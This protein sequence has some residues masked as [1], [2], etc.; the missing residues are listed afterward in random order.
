VTPLV[1]LRIL[2]LI[3][4][5]SLWSHKVKNAIVGAIMMFGTFLVV[6]GSA[7]LDS[8][9]DS[10]ARSITSSMSGHLQV[11]SADA[12]D[13]LSLFGSFGFGSTDIGE[14]DDFAKVERSLLQVDNVAAVVPMGISIVTVFG[15]NDIDKAL[16]ELRAAV[17]EGDAEKTKVLTGRVRR[18]A[19]NIQGDLDA[20]ARIARDQEKVAEDKAVLARATSDEFWASFET[21]PLPALDFLDSQVAPQAA[22]GRLLYLRVIGTDLSRFTKTFDRFHVVKG[23][24]VPEGRRGLL[25][26]DRTHEKLLKNLVARELDGIREDLDGGA[27]I[28][29]DPLLQEKVARLAKQ[30]QSILFQLDADESA[31]LEQALRA[32]LPSEGGDLAAQLRAFI[33]GMD[34]TN[35]RQR[36]DFFYRE[37]A[38]RISLYDVNVGD[39]ITLRSFTK[40]GYIKAVNV[41]VYG[42]YE[43]YG[44]EKS[45]LAS[46]SN[47]LDMITW[48]DLYGK[49]SADQVAELDQ[50]KQSVGVKEISRESAEDALFGGGGEVEA[51]VEPPSAAFDEFEDVRLSDRAERQE[52][53]DTKVYSPEE[54]GGGLALNAA[55]VLR[56]AERLRETQKAVEERSAADDL[57]LQVVDWQRAAGLLGQF[58]IVMR[59][60]LYVAI[61]VIFLVALV[62][63]NNSMVMAT[64]ERTPEIGTMRAI[65]AQRSFVMLLFLVETVVLGCIAGGLGMALGSA[66]VGWLG[67]IGIP[68]V[69]DILVVL[70]AGPRLYPSV[71][72]GNLLFGFGTILV[73]SLLSTMYPAIL[74]ARVAPIVAMQGKE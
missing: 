59:V 7:L 36:Y 41:R 69:A 17:R 52:A 60:V 62:I 44:L 73:V 25:I 66:F 48:R 31:A 12:E 67:H 61:F 71:H 58:I 53:L 15:G 74:A 5:R 40:S 57:G 46:A 42:T 23:E 9:E 26:S 11:Y 6:T 72:A 18:I 22:D 54:I 4:L 16:T 20:L 55:I 33:A 70:F 56:D 47:L 63:I 43:F 24:D 64:M 21:D 19:E 13:E 32:E 30:Y 1:R 45:D 37:I 2:V 50:I 8:M 28:A 29:G 39:V 14:I 65:G 10:M 35:F 68:A 51:A 49:M 34:D 3:A 38:P 27:T